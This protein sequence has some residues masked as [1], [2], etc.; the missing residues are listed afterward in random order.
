[1]RTAAIL[2]I[3]SL[4]AAKQRLSEELAGGS[5]RALALAMFTDVLA[6]LRRVRRLD[7]I[8]VVTRDRVAE[9]A[10]QAGRVEVLREQDETGQSSAALVGIRDA[11]DGGFDRVL[12]VPAD[13]PLLDPDELD[14]LLERAEAEE[15]GAVI[16]PDRHGTGTN[17]LLLSPPDA[18]EPGFGPGSLERHLAAAR[19]ASLTH[20]VDPVPSLVL[21]VDTGDDLAALIALLEERRGKAPTTRGALRQLDRLRASAGAVKPPSTERTPA[22]A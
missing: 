4:D 6:A 7:S 15:L 18:I 9:S 12:L 11:L 22:R 10:A 3:K 8:T 5:R 20:V 21:D 2:P 16:V 1:M 17:A 19:T 14:A 13:T